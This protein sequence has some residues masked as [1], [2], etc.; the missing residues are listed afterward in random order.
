MNCDILGVQYLIL[1]ILIL[2]LVFQPSLGISLSM[3]SMELLS[4]PKMAEVGR[5]GPESE[6][7]QPTPLCRTCKGP[8]TPALLPP[9]LPPRRCDKRTRDRSP[10]A[11]HPVLCLIY[12]LIAA[13][14]RRPPNS[15]KWAR[16]PCLSAAGR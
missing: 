11:A 3:V 2:G 12:P 13:D 14:S 5:E 6:N 9:P 16:Q 4:R 15:A 1:Y 7:S 8:C 10:A